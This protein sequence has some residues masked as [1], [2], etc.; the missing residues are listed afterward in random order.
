VLN[1]FVYILH[2]NIFASVESD[3][4]LALIILCLKLTFENHLEIHAKSILLK[5]R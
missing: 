4:T 1:L 2:V 5:T 3:E